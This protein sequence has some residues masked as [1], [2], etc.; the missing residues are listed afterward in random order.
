M[1][2]SK[3][4]SSS[5]RRW[6]RVYVRQRRTQRPEP[7][8][9]VRSNASAST[10]PLLAKKGVFDEFEVKTDVARN[11]PYADYFAMPAL[12]NGVG[13]RSGTRIKIWSINANMNLHITQSGNSTERI[14]GELIYLVYRKGPLTTIPLFS[15]IFQVVGLSTA[16]TGSDSLPSTGCMV[17]H[18]MLDRV[19]ILRRRNFVMG[20]NTS[21][22]TGPNRLML[23]TYMKFRGRQAMYCEFSDDALQGTIGGIKKNLLLTY[24][25]MTAHSGC[26]IECTHK[27]RMVFYH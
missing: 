24:V 15:D 4:Q 13:Q 2:Y 23:Q 3:K 7:T 5:S 19:H 26:R 8:R 10:R 12:G 25:V 18:E 22:T 14:Y 21:Q 20:A 17:K 9:M 16:E 11:V 1:A 27:T 6:G